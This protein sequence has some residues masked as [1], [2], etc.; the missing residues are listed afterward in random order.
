MKELEKRGVPTVSLVAD[1]FVADHQRSAETLG[2]PALP[3]ARMPYPFVNQKPS[4]IREMIDAG[5]D[6]IVRALTL[7]PAATSGTAAIKFIAD[8][9][10][11]F[12][13]VDQLDAIDLMNGA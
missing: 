6:Q 7:A 10:V 4:M 1:H 9:W 12:E 8:P 11:T 13:G 3:F 2:I 5:I